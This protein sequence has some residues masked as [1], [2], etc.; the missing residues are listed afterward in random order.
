M[1]TLSFM[2]FLEDGFLQVFKGLVDVVIIG[3][4][5]LMKTIFT[6]KVAPEVSLEL[7]CR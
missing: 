1:K 4:P 5:E 7:L 6:S 2:N 3:Q